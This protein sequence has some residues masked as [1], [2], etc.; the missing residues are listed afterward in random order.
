MKADVN[1]YGF[2]FD[3]SVTKDL[4][5]ITKKMEEEAKKPNPDKDT[6][7]KLRLQKL[8]RGMEMNTSMGSRYNGIPW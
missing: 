3:N 6:I 1:T 5:E 8:Y 7:M 2:Q 4:S